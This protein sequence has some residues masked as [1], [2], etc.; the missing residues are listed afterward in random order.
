[1]RPLWERILVWS[2]RLLMAGIF[3]KF[4]WD[5]LLDPSDFALSIYHYRMLPDAAINP[6]AIFLPWLEW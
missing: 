5:K 4:A 1:V 3:M 2:A 6:L